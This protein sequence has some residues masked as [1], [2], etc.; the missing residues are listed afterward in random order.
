[1][2]R[3][4][5]TELNH[6]IENGNTKGEILVA[7]LRERQI[8][9]VTSMAVLGIAGIIISAGFGHY[10]AGQGTGAGGPRPVRR[11]FFRHTDYI[12]VKG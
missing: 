10:T 1:M 11:E 2:I 4:A 12:P 3:E 6:L 7:G 5:Q 9:T 8:N